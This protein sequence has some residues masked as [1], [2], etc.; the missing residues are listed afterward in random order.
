[1]KNKTKYFIAFILA[2]VFYTYMVIQ[3]IA[4]IDCN[5]TRLIY[6]ILAQ[7]LIALIFFPTSK[8]KNKK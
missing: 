3:I 1:M 7:A 6:G 5:T 2:I 4:E 8:K